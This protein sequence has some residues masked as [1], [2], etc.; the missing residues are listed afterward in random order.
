MCL[1]VA[2]ILMLIGG[3]YALIAGRIKLTKNMLLTGPRAR[4]AGLILL[5]PLPLAL[6]IGFLLGALVGVG[7]LPTSAQ[8]FAPCVEII[9]VIVCLLGAVLFAF[10][11]K[12]RETAEPASPDS[13][14]WTDTIDPEHISPDP[15]PWTDTI[16]PKPD[17]P[18]HTDTT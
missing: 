1:L 17:P 7:I 3:L 9:L 14:P 10:L 11:T 12:P 6:I 13:T 2:E 8:D 5:A 16:D 15:T 18:E 4:V